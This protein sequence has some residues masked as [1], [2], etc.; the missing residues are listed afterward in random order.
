VCLRRLP[1][2]RGDRELLTAADLGEPSRAP[3]P[4]AA[5]TAVVPAGFSRGIDELVERAAAAGDDIALRCA[6][7]AQR[8]VEFLTHGLYPGPGRNLRNEVMAEN[9][10]WILEREDRVVVGA[11][12]VHVQRTPS[13]VGTA[14]IGSLLAPVL[15]NDL[16]VIG[17]TRAAGAVPEPPNLNAD[18]HGRFVTLPSKL[19]PLP[20]HS[21]DAILD[22]LG[23]R[24]T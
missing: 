5:G 24:C 10:H 19:P 7:G 22:T 15:G 6:L 20:S 2:Q 18:P 17:T 1:P 3:S 23:Y 13:F 11:H 16:V 8:V 14:P 9:L 4:A 12:N 21:L